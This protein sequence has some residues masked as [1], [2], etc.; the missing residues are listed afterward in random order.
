[1]GNLASEV[2]LPNLQPSPAGDSGKWKGQAGL[3]RHLREFAGGGREEAGS[4]ESHLTDGA[5]GADAPAL[6]PAVLQRHV[7]K[8][9]GIFPVTLDPLGHPLPHAL[10]QPELGLL[11]LLHG[12]VALG[13]AQL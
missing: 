7:V 1:M 5:V 12:P 11:H 3:P 13:A 9:P 4:L 10:Q 8:Q 6:A 2:D